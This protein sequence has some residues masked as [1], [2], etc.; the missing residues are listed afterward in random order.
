M[1][2][3]QIIINTFDA[4]QNGTN[5]IILIYGS[6]WWM[7]MEVKRNLILCEMVERTR[8]ISIYF[9]QSKYLYSDIIVISSDKA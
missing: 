7:W 8:P 1:K 2:V 3:Y 5:G 9:T 4:E 6:S